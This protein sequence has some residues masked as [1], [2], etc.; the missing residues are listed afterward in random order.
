MEIRSKIRS[1]ITIRSQKSPFNEVLL[2][3]EVFAAA[4]SARPSS[5]L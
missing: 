5:R 1:R 3:D 2:Q 4:L